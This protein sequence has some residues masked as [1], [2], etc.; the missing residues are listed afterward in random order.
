MALNFLSGMNLF[1]SIIALF[2]SIQ[3]IIKG[4]KTKDNSGKINAILGFFAA[5][6]TLVSIFTPWYIQIPLKTCIWYLILKSSNI[7]DA[8]LSS[9][10]SIKNYRGL[11]MIPIITRFAIV[12][13]FFYLVSVVPDIIESFTESTPD[14]VI[15]KLINIGIVISVYYVLLFVQSSV[16]KVIYRSI[17]KDKHISKDS[18]KSVQLSF[19]GIRS[20][21]NVLSLGGDFLEVPLMSLLLLF[22][23]IQ[24]I[25]RTHKNDEDDVGEDRFFA[26]IACPEKYLHGGYY[27]ILGST[28]LNLIILEF[29]LFSG[30][31][32]TSFFI[33]QEVI[34]PITIFLIY[35]IVCW[36]LVYME[37]RSRLMIW[38]LSGVLLIMFFLLSLYSISIIPFIKYLDYIFSW[39]PSF[40]RDIGN[41]FVVFAQ[42]LLFGNCVRSVFLNIIEFERENKKQ[43]QRSKSFSNLPLSTQ[44][45]SPSSLNKPNIE[46]VHNETQSRIFCTN[47]GKA[48]EISKKY[49]DNCGEKLTAN[50]SD[51]K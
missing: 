33:F 51:V 3:E 9:T 29:T 22:G 23:S 7:P 43:K 28:A 20:Y 37:L 44:T 39:G 36:V 17:E 34:F 48:H 8:N 30:L 6:L 35:A 49:C 15:P 10:N 25:T 5:I 45:S 50:S 27:F 40:L 42:W 24:K 18:K 16:K 14:L 19:D 12:E 11:Y 46:E 13:I 38:I 41:I 26:N 31:E 2:F 4:F 32:G 1:L 47:C 21:N